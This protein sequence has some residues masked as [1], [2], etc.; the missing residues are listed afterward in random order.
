MAVELAAA[1][2]I[3][4]RI[5]NCTNHV[6][7]TT[8]HNSLAM[9]LLLA[10]DVMLISRSVDDG[11]LFAWSVDF[12]LIDRKHRAT[13][14]CNT[15]NLILWP[16]FPWTRTRILFSENGKSKFSDIGKKR[17]YMIK[18]NRLHATCKSLLRCPAASVN[19]RPGFD[20]NINSQEKGPV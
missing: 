4:R 7:R 13:Q 12:T 17:K 11:C 18:I 19:A 2:I 10:N 15:M 3:V 8:T 20:G 6:S 14:T 1:L 9:R 5:N 16:P